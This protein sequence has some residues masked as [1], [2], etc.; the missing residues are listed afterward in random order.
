MADYPQHPS[1]D[2]RSP[3]A[4]KLFLLV[5]ALIMIPVILTASIAYFTVSYQVRTAAH[6]RLDDSAKTYALGALT[7]IELAVDAAKLL[8]ERAMGPAWSLTIDGDPQATRFFTDV[9]ILDAAPASSTATPVSV[10]MVESDRANFVNFRILVAVSGPDGQS[11]VLAAT[12]RPEFVWGSPDYFPYRV[13]YCAFASSGQLLFCPDES[14]A[15]SSA[16]LLGLL[17]DPDKEQALLTN[18]GDKLLVSAWSLPLGNVG[19]D[20]RVNMFAVQPESEALVGAQAFAELMP[21]VFAI[22]LVLAAWIAFVAIRR[23]LQPLTVLAEAASRLS[24]GDFDS[25]I[26]IDSNDEFS[27]L[28][29]AF[30]DMRKRLG[31]QFT[32]IGALSEIDSMILNSCSLE[33]IAE[34]TVEQLGRITP[35]VTVWVTIFSRDVERFGVTFYA[36]QGVVHNRRTEFDPGIHGRLTAAP[37][38]LRLD[39]PLLDT[40]AICCPD[41]GITSAFVLPIRSDDRPIGLLGIGSHSPVA[42]EDRK[43]MM[44]FADRLAVAAASLEREERL[45]HMG[46]Y[47]ALTGLANRSLMAK[48]LKDAVD[49]SLKRATIGALLFIDLDGFKRVNDSEGHSVGDQ[50]LRIAGERIRQAVAPHHTVARLGGDEFTVMLEDVQSRDEIG[51]ICESILEVMRH[52]F[53]IERLEHFVSGTIGVA[54]FPLDGNDVETLLRNADTAMYT[55]KDDGRNTYAFFEAQMNLDVADRVRSES[56]LRQALSRGELLAYYQPKIDLGSGAVVGAEALLR[57]QHPRHG[58]C[59]PE[60]FIDLAEQTGLIVDIGLW[61]LEQ[62]CRDFA[63]WSAEGL[64]PGSVAVN[65]SQRQL[66]DSRFVDELADILDRTGLPPTNLELEITE[67]MFAQPGVEKTFREI[68]RL[69]VRIAVDDFGTGY[70]SFG[71][72]RRFSIDTIKVD[73]IFLVGLPDDADAAAVINAIFSVADSLKKDVVVEGIERDCEDEFLRQFGGLIGQGYLY[74]VPA[75]GKGFREYLL[76]LAGRT[77]VA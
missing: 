69:G 6:Q 59:T 15:E 73:R 3:V 19:L 21:R 44:K 29:Q 53:K 62:A 28:G 20:D 33:P 16:S 18:E 58:L 72:L 74:A 43:A 56:D 24:G 25:T 49:N 38:G 14:L 5:V 2:F 71:Y 61:I 47:D 39:V 46:H 76:E 52:P 40:A 13:T 54:L 9:K 77:E 11:R 57:W 60:S 66:R 68:Q 17:A 36:T 27:H 1:S 75:S 22:A 34:H 8:A 31:H 67:H 41:D 48:S 51:A 12:T 32:T 35:G 45:F 30:N 64:A 10:R 42:D 7:R 50:L 70:S 4:R 63:H 23:R 65:V 26:R 55:A 37:G